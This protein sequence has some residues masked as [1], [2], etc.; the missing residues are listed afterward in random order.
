MKRRKPIQ[1]SESTPTFSTPTLCQTDT[2]FAAANWVSWGFIRKRSVT[3]LG[4][5][6][7]V[8]IARAEDS[9]LSLHTWYRHPRAERWTAVGKAFLRKPLRLSMMP[10]FN[11]TVWFSVLRQAA[12]RTTGVASWVTGERGMRCMRW[13]MRE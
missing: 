9:T 5:R 3:K 13:S 2:T 1:S 7:L 8:E 4:A 11:S 12:A 6:P 10:C